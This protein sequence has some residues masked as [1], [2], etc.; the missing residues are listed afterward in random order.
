LAVLAHSVLALLV[1]IMV[2]LIILDPLQLRHH[3]RQVNAKLKK[4]ILEFVAMDV[5]WNQFVEFDTNVRS[6]PI[7][8]FARV[9]NPKMF[10]R[11]I[12][13]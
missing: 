4:F 2:L 11:S 8:I 13:S 6:V 7:M 9:A 1:V 5:T 3:P 10:T 12:L